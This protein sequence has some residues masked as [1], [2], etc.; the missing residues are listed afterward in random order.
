[1]AIPVDYDSL[2]NFWLYLAWKGGLVGLALVVLALGGLLLYSNRIT[3]RLSTMNQRCFA[4]ALQA[5]FIGQLVA[6]CAMPRLTYANGALF[7]VIWTMAFV[8]LERNAASNKFPCVASDE[9]DNDENDL[10]DDYGHDDEEQP[11]IETAPP[12]PVSPI[13]EKL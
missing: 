6:S 3:K 13:L 1:S 4:R 5:I 10:D 11:V 2:H 8:L 7:L 12:R 9:L